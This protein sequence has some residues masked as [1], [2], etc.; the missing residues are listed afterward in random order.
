MNNN[1]DYRKDDEIHFHCGFNPFKMYIKGP[2]SRNHPFFKFSRNFD[3]FFRKGNYGSIFSTAFVE[4]NDEAYT[5]TIEIPGIKKENVQLEI[6][7]NELWLKAKNEDLKKDYHEHLHFKDAI[8]PN[9]VKA[10]LNAGI[11]TITAPY[12]AK[13]TKTKV[14]IE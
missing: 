14:N 13:K 12:A 5:I 10:N 7:P 1:N 9:K 11:L 3:P 6:T 2:P 8:D 4:K